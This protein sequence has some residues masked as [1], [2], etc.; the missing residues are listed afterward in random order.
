M[1][2]RTPAQAGSALTWR[3]AAMPSSS[4]IRMSISTTSGW[5][6]RTRLTASRPL[7]ASPA[8]G[9]VVLGLDQH[10]QPH[11]HQGL[12]VGQRH[13][14][15]HDSSHPSGSTARTTSPPPGRASTS[16]V[17]PTARARSP[18]P[19]IPL[20]AAGT[21]VAGPSSL[22]STTSRPGSCLT[23]TTAV[24]CSACRTT[25]V[26]ASW[27]IR[28]AAWSTAAGSGVAAPSPDHLDRPTGLPQRPDEV[29]EPGQPRYRRPRL[30]ALRVAEHLE[31]RPQLGQRL[32]AGG[33]D[34]LQ[35]RRNLVRAPIQYVQR[36]PG[37]HGDHRQA[38][39][40]HVVHVPGDPH[41][42]LVRVPPPVLLAGHPL[43]LPPA[44]PEQGEQGR[45]DGQRDAEHEGRV[46]GRVEQAE[47]RLRQY[48]AAIIGTSRAVNGSQRCS[49]RTM[50][51]A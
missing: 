39:A 25:L 30:A 3:R 33:S 21:V 48:P 40:D 20:P 11:P 17:P 13:R 16:S 27:M 7:S 4:G 14:D 49:G 5:V 29:V 38:V 46:E 31:R 8:S 9:Q 18:M 22:T 12:V 44:P 26:S 51:M 41:P 37:L 10:P 42:L 32:A 45:H 34:R 50:A 43:T 23:R 35:R 24:A 47:V 36:H 6:R 15:R 2:T 28:K 19:R 1:I